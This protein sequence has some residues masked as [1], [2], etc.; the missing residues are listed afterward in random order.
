MYNAS[1]NPTKV[2]KHNIQKHSNII[3]FA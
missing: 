1:W 2:F 3:F